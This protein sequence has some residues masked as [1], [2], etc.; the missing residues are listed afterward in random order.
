MPIDLAFDND[1][2]M[3]LIAEANKTG[4]IYVDPNNSTINVDINNKEMGM[5]VFKA[6]IPI[7]D[8]LYFVECSNEEFKVDNYRRRTV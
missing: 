1:L 8:F 7:D 4:R 5:N 3:R 2:I 6:I